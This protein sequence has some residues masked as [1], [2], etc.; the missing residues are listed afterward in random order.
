L[1]P[2]QG[3]VADVGRPRALV[4]RH[5]DV[6]GPYEIATA[7]RRHGV[8]AVDGPPDSLDGFDALVV[9]GGPMAAHSDDDFPTRTAELRLL[10]DALDRRVPVLGVCLGA[11]LLAVAAG[12]R[13]FRGEAGPEIGWAPVH[14]VGE[15]RLF[16]DLPTSFPV[17]HWHGD[18]VELPPGAELLASSDRY[19]NQAFRVGPVAWGIQFHLEVDLGAVGA[20][21]ERFDGDPAILAEAADRL[22]EL[23]P[24]RALVLDRW[25][26]LV[27]DPI[28]RTQ[29]FFGRRAAGWDD[30]FGD[31][32]AA[33]RAAAAELD[34]PAGAVVLDV[35]CGTGRALPHLGAG[36][37]G[38]D[39]TPEM[40]GVAR[41][42]STRLALADGARLPLRDGAVDAVFAAGFV[43]HLDDPSAG[44]AELRRVTR[45]G[46]RLAIFHPIG[47]AT[48]AARHGHDLRPDDLLAAGNV[49]PALLAAGWT[50]DRVDDGPERYLAVA[51][52]T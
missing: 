22:A 39:A 17:L 21:V 1:L 50:L 46:G 31:D 11:Q 52:A 38:I 27:A 23:A 41:D 35:G 14:R 32:D 25:A 5:L 8:D 44:L 34:V 24:T 12:G 26:T 13:A 40:L 30:R 45:T 28:R 7:L 36:A 3:I 10:A 19:T 9:M 2:H 43:T 4:V 49:G 47:R 42:R 20:F 48:L 37:V 33:Y 18:T 15:D 29:S 16:A 51:S 6:E